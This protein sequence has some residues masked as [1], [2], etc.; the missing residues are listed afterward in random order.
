MGIIKLPR[1]SVGKI[2]FSGTRW[3]K[4]ISDPESPPEEE[5]GGIDEFT[6]LML[7]LDGDQSDSHHIVTFN[8]SVEYSSTIKK[9]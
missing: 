3:Q 8:G 6:K 1:W 5:V 4:S 9:F 2:G 7:H